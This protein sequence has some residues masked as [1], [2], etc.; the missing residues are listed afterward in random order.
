[1]IYKVENKINGYVYVGQTTKTLEQR[2]QHHIY[3]LKCYKYRSFF[4]AA[5][6]KYGIENFEWGCLEEC[7]NS[8]LDDREAFWISIYKKA[9]KSYNILDGGNPS[10][11]RV[12]T[13]SVE[14]Y[15]ED[16]VYVGRFNSLTEASEQ[17]FI[18]IS[19]ISMCIN[20]KRCSAGRINGKRLLWC[21]SGELVSNKSRRKM[22]I[23]V[24]AYTKDNKFSKMFD[25]AIEGAKFFGLKTQ[26]GVMRSVRNTSRYSGKH[27]GIP[28]YWKIRRD[29]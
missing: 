25:T 4:Y 13:I 8:M 21:K 12:N 19:A 15:T 14:A 16:G 3:D 20:K 24:E 9:G 27:N 26:G 17:T 22:G 29:V 7:P 18:D 23:A 5:I 2:K 6:K 1:M 28:V 10:L 11:Q